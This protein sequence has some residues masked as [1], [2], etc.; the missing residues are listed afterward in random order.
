MVSGWSND[1]SGRGQRVHDIIERRLRAGADEVRSVVPSETRRRTL[2]AL[3]AA[4]VSTV[5][6]RREGGRTP[7]Y[8]LAAAATVVVAAVLAVQMMLEFLGEE[9]GARCIEKAIEDLV[10][11]GTFTSFDARSGISTV[12]FGDTIV[13]ALS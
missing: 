13:D 3:D 6:P 4:A 1:R 12:E 8:Y 2:A 10:A 7:T 9:A 11:S 5:F